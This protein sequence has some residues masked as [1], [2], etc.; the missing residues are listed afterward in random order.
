LGEAAQKIKGKVAPTTPKLHLNHHQITPQTTPPAC[1]KYPHFTPLIYPAT[2]ITR[3]N[4]AHIEKRFPLL[5]K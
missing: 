5:S 4:L 2:R 1:S 3:K